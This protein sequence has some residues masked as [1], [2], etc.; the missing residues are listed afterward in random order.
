MDDQGE[1][2]G[3]STQGSRPRALRV[4]IALEG[5]NS[6]FGLIWPVF[7]P[8]LSPGASQ[9]WGVRPVAIVMVIS[10]LSLINLVIISGLWMRRPWAFRAGIII[11]V[12]SIAIDIIVILVSITQRVL[13]FGA[14]LAL[15]LNSVVLSLFLQS[16]V[17]R[18]VIEWKES[19]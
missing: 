19:G 13:D 5:V 16:K 3:M 17:I 7:L 12:F 1:A 10:V 18:T 14:L 6:L 8:T 2:E 4:L 15:V 11:T 9:P